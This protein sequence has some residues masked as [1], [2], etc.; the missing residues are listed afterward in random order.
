MAKMARTWWGEKF[1]DALAVSM[2]IGR[3]KRGRSYAGPNRLLEFDISGHT[4][5]A[6]VRGNVNHYFGVYEE[7]RY[8]VTVRLKPITAEEWERIADS[9][10]RNAAFLSQ[11]LMDELPA[12]IERVFTEHN[13][14]L[15]P[16]TRTDLISKCSCPDY[17]SPC[18]HVAGVY[19]KIA[20]LLDRDPM[21]LFQLRGLQFTTMQEKLASSDLGQ[22]LLVQKDD[23]DRM[24]E[25]SMHCFTDPQ[26]E[27]LKS[28][29]LKSFWQGDNPLPL[30][31]YDSSKTATPAILI[32]RGGEYPA[33]W[34]LD[35][36]FIE[37]MERVY[38]RIVD[39]N[40]ASL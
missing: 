30:V 36:S 13:R 11:L 37:V 10:S 23:S 16:R 21:L 22:A 34:N 7:P 2:D 12:N 9:I 6:K 5:K 29:D 39:K 40:K 35:H 15:L 31:E 24:I 20:A 27:P 1:L 8:N 17:A 28:D 25:Y 14:Y 38:S 18:K 3:L 33:F 19:Y 32:K 4:V 26:V